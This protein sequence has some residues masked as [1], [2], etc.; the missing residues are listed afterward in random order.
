MMKW[1]GE[2]PLIVSGSAKVSVFVAD[3]YMYI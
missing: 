3:A 2:I 1:S